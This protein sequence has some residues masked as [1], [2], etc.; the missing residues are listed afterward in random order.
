[1][2]DSY[3]GKVLLSG[4]KVREGISYLMNPDTSRAS[5]QGF[6]KVYQ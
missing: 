2:K 4:R 6:H 5:N 1:M 3:E